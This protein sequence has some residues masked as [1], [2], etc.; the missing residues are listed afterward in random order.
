MTRAADEAASTSRMEPR[1]PTRVVANWND[2]VGLEGI[3][4]ARVR[5]LAA[6]PPH[7]DLY[8]I[9]AAGPL[10][11]EGDDATLPSPLPNR[12]LVNADVQ[13]A[14][15]AAPDQSL[16]TLDGETNWMSVVTQSGTTANQIDATDAYTSVAGVPLSTNAAGETVSTGQAN[17]V[18]DGLG[19][20]VS[21]TS[22][23]K[24]VSYLY[25]A[26]GR[27]VG[28][29]VNAGTVAHLDLLRVGRRRPSRND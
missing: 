26:L 16:L 29:T 22:G 11:A 13:A 4:R 20:L 19:H 5:Q 3:P 28:E 21:A 12:E 7:T 23:S 25:D 14:L 6:S 2:F 1:A 15:S 17:L 8:E 9:D 27:R 24:S 18:F 10:I